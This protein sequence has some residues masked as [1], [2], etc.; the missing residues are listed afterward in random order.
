MSIDVLLSIFG[1]ECLAMRHDVDVYD[2]LQL[3]DSRRW[4]PIWPRRVVAAVSYR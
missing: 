2:R 3:S 4:N 1:R